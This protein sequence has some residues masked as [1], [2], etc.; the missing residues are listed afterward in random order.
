MAPRTS[1]AGAQPKGRPAGSGSREAGENPEEEEAIRQAISQFREATDEEQ[2][3]A[4]L[5]F[6]GFRDYMQQLENPLKE[7]SI[8]SY[9]QGIR[10]LFSRDKRSF[11]DMAG[12]QYGTLI[13]KS[14]ANRKG[15][16][17]WSASCLKFRQFYEAHSQEGGGAFVVDPEWAQL[18]KQLSLKECEVDARGFRLRH[19]TDRGGRNGRFVGVSWAEHVRRWAAVFKGKYLG[20]FLTQEKAAEAIF[21]AER[22]KSVHATGTRSLTTLW[23][24]LKAAPAAST[25]GLPGAAQPAAAQPP[26]ADIAQ[27]DL[28]QVAQVVPIVDPLSM[29][30]IEK[31]VRGSNCEHIECFDHDTFMHFNKVQQ[32][33]GS[34]LSKRW[35]CPICSKFAH[36]ET[37]AVAKEFE[38]VLEAAKDL[39]DVTHVNAL[40]DGRLAIPQ[41][42]AADSS[43][44]GA[45]NSSDPAKDLPGASQAA[46]DVPNGQLKLPLGEAGASGQGAGETSDAVEEIRDDPPGSDAARAPVPAAGQA[47]GAAR[48]VRCV[49][50]S[51]ATPPAGAQANRTTPPSKRPRGVRG[52]WTECK[53]AKQSAP[54]SGFL[55]SFCKTKVS[56]GENPE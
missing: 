30:R 43:A 18:R 48:E 36:P 19:E 3:D 56:A 25:A 1:K 23:G 16:G 51:D 54:Q 15:H 44:P 4:E 12:E 31:P 2:R 35:L 39:P 41:G 27:E 40:P 6:L 24:P 26:P 49:P 47:S 28:V 34:R 42:D 53:V 11:A 37:L 46:D 55:A 32:K 50:E 5:V 45:G 38:D 17:V 52:E 20:S 29:C 7:T 13:K 9:F 14:W 10:Q 21:C 33:A 8:H 22:G